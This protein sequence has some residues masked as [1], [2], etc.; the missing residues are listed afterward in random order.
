MAS[1][2]LLPPR[3]AATPAAAAGTAAARASVTPGG[4]PMP[5]AATLYREQ[6]TSVPST[7][8]FFNLAAGSHATAAAVPIPS[9]TSTHMTVHVAATFGQKMSP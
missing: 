7:A 1:C 4:A 5:A 9:S 3:A 8:I 2:G 6:I